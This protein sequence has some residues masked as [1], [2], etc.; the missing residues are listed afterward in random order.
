MG[1]GSTGKGA[2]LEGFD[3]I[4]IEQNA[5][6]IEIAKARIQHARDNASQKLFPQPV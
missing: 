2:T 5:E 3:F 4:G 1:S 6:Y